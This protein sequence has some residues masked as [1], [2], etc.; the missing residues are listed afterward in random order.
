MKKNLIKNIK[1]RILLKKIGILLIGIGI[2]GLIEAFQYNFPK[3]L[4]IVIQ[5][6]IRK[7]HAAELLNVN[8]DNINVSAFDGD[9]NFYQYI[10]Q[11]LRQNNDKIDATKFTQELMNLSQKNAY[12]PIFILAVIKTESAFNF[13]AIGSAGEIGLMQIKPTTAEWICKKKKI[14]WMGA[15]ALKNPEYNMLVG[16]HYF[17]YLK[18]SLKSQ[19][20]KYVNAYNLGMTSMNRKLS[21][22]LKKHPYFGKVTENYLAIY[23]ELKKIKEKKII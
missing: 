2:W 22:D 10:A 1:T 11:Y 6:V 19:S 21:K 18:K 17:K 13:D 14:K 20:L 5:D 16:A 23:S 15:N 4:N 8:A 7:N 3:D 9:A 12:D